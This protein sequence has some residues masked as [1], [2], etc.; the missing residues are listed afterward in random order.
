MAF[1][2][3]EKECFRQHSQLFNLYPTPNG[4]S[5]A[6]GLQSL[7]PALPMRPAMCFQSACGHN[8]TTRLSMS[9]RYSFGD[10]AADERGA[11]GFS[12]TVE[13]ESQPCSTLTGSAPTCYRR[14]QLPRSAR[15]QSSVCAQL[16]R[17][18]QLWRREIAARLDFSQASLF[19]QHSS[20][21]A[22]SQREEHNP[23][24]WQ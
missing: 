11:G 15:I 13:T 9:A 7:R 8:F 2:E 4:L 10:S 20:F 22:D 16:F 19:A 3:R 18:R 24:G 21:S 1:T 23:D 17:A 14:A 6:D 5:R 12:L